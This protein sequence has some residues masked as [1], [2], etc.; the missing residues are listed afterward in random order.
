VPRSARVAA[1]ALLVT[2]GLVAGAAA[3]Q[4]KGDYGD[5]AYLQHDLDNVR[6]STVSGRQL[7]ELEDLGYGE[8]LTPLAARTFLTNL[9][10]Q[11]ADLP[12]GRAYLTLGQLLPGGAV[13]NPRTAR[14]LTPTTVA[15]TSRTGAKLLG[16][17]W[18]DGRPGP[19]PG[20]VITP[21]SI[22][23]TQHMYF[24]AARTL[25]QAGFEVLTF[26][27]QG[28]GESETFG[29]HPPSWLPTTDGVPFQQE[30]NF[31]DG[32]VDALRFLLSSPGQPYVPGGWTAPQV[33]A[34]RYQA[35]P[36]LDWYNPG[37]AALDATRVGLAGHSLGARAVS[38]V[39]Q[40]SDQAQLWR[41][42]AVCTGR[43]FPIRAVVAWDR[44][45]DQGV[46]PVVPAMDQEADGYFLFPEPTTT[47]PDPRAHLHALTTWTKA[48]IDTYALTIRGGTHLEWVDVPYI[49]PSTTYGVLAAARY[50][51]A[52]MQ[53]YLSPDPAVQRQ[54]STLL[55]TSPKDDAVTHGATQWPWA[56]SFLSANYLGGFSFHDPAGGRHQ[57]TDLRRYGGTS[58]VGDWAGANRDQ[59]TARVVAPG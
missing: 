11:V 53:R 20:I 33:R 40:C 41:R 39:Q 43:S 58:P 47:A 48:G 13:G 38:V 56:A 4:A 42:L 45:S 57:V 37:A 55:L 35:D 12:E 9:G 17:V 26:D 6:R 36:S 54:A 28:Q 49:L 44:L 19:H 10:R 18:L 16:R 23:G 15:F 25:A 21:G 8:A 51:L 34:A 29:H 31:V 1:L 59:P 52:W 5:P 3:A 32:T 22:Q 7:A 30:A 2:A 50:T 27:A 46:T 14:A 24:W